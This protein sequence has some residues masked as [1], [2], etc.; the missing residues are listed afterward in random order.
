MPRYLIN[1][2]VSQWL[3]ETVVKCCFPEA[4][5]TDEYDKFL[6]PW[7]GDYGQ[8]RRCDVRHYNGGIELVSPGEFCKVI[9]SLMEDALKPS[10][11]ILV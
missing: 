1:V 10:S 4:R 7:F 9:H 5:I 6:L 2:L 8:V 11:L 3:K